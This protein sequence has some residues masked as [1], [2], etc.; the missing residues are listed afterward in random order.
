MKRERGAN[1]DTNQI[2]DEKKE[3]IP[4]VMETKT[5]PV[6]ALRG[7]TVLPGM[8]VHFDINRSITIEAVEQAMKADQQAFLVM[9]ID[10]EVEEPKLA[11]LHRVGTIATIKQIIKLPGNVIR[12]MVCGNTRA[13]LEQLEKHNSFL[14]GKVTECEKG[15]EEAWNEVER[16]AIL[17]HLK[18]LIELYSIEYP[19]VGKDVAKQL[20]KLKSVEDL[21]DQIAAN[22]PMIADARQKV[23]EAINLQQRYEVLSVI[24][25]EEIEIGRIRRD[26]QGKVKD[27][28]DKNQ[29]DYLLREQLKVIREELGESNVVD[30][31]DNYMEQLGELDAS[32]E[33]KEAIE[34]EINRFRQLSN[35]SAE[36]SVAR[37]Y[38]ETILALPWNKSDKEEID[39]KS[40]ERI[41]N[42][43]HYGLTKVKERVLEYLAVRAYTGKDSSQV[44]CLVG[45]PGT[46]KTSIAH[47]IANCMGRKYT[48]VCLGGVRDEA[49]IRGHRRTYVGALPGR[50]IT[51]LKNAKINNPVMLLDEI[52]KIGS[53]YK[54]DPASA[55]LEILDGEQNK[56]FVDH[57]IEIPVDL[58]K[59]TFIADRKSVV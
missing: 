29:K 34:K 58:S 46:G 21:I 55:L 53:D 3:Q 16:E 42:K 30:D 40:S 15:A 14:L 51:A 37:G 48:R 54:G 45:P 31:A 57:Y 9:Q 17:R 22:Y 49:E 27:K 38:L 13:V 12:V 56:E 19:K 43:E 59:V 4:N 11:D 6:I 32:K 39:I 24:L 25:T 52:D 8:L 5:L 33:I 1:M 18:G 36:S 20:F 2:M 35:S 26:I 47:S 41:L 44:I 10:E 28:V 7:M 50:I 23:L